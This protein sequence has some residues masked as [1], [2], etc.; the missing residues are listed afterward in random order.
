MYTYFYSEKVEG[1]ND[2]QAYKARYDNSSLAFCV[3]DLLYNKANKICDFKFIYV[4]RM[5]AKIGKKT[6]QELLNHSFYSLYPDT[7]KKWLSY[8][9]SVA[10]DGVPGN[11]TEFS[12]EAQKTINIQAYQI[13]FG[14]CGCLLSAVEDD[15]N[16]QQ[17]HQTK[18]NIKDQEN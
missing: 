7:D 13:S 1:K 12:Q 2:L 5:F 6:T 9:I 3:I 16:T 10:I 4:N 8:C 14:R 15:S 17:S 18:W 11:F